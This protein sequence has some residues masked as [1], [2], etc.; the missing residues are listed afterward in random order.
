MGREGADSGELD[1]LQDVLRR[2]RFFLRHYGRFAETSLRDE[3]AG[4]VDSLEAAMT[5]NMLERARD[6]AAVICRTLLFGSSVACVLLAAER[7]VAA[8]DPILGDTIRHQAV[9]LRE[10]C[11]RGD[12]TEVVT[13]RLLRTGL[14]EA[15]GKCE[16]DWRNIRELLPE[17][18]FREDVHLPSEGTLRRKGSQASNVPSS[19]LWS[20]SGVADAII[21][22]GYY[23]AP[24]SVQWRRR[25]AER[26]LSKLS[27]HH[28]ALFFKS[29]VLE[30]A[31]EVVTDL[32]FEQLGEEQE[33][34]QSYVADRELDFSG[35][36]PY[37]KALFFN[38]VVVHDAFSAKV[39]DKKV[40]ALRVLSWGESLHWA[41]KTAEGRGRRL[42]DSVRFGGARLIVTVVTKWQPL[43]G[44]ARSRAVWVLA[45]FR[46][47]FAFISYRRDTGWEAAQL[48][49]AIL[50]THQIRVFLDV[51]SSR[52]GEFAGT[53]EE[54]IARA[55]GVVVVLTRGSL[56]SGRRGPDDYFHKEIL[57][58]KKTGKKIIPVAFRGFRFHGSMPE[59]LRFLK[60]HQQ[61]RWQRGK[62]RKAV[63]E[64]VDFVSG[65]QVRPMNAER[66]RCSP[67]P[68]S[69]PGV[70]I[71]YDP[72]H[73]EQVAWILY[74]E[75]A[76]R[77]ISAYLDLLDRTPGLEEELT[78]R[79][80]EQ[81][82][83]F[84]VVLNREKSLQTLCDKNSLFSKQ[85]AYALRCK[86]DCEIVPFVLDDLDV[87]GVPE[88]LRRLTSLRRVDFTVEDFSEAVED[89]VDFCEPEGAVRQ[90]AT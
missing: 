13:R 67:F 49:R 65:K 45:F 61:V 73:G 50:E 72:E 37:Q 15:L 20:A 85:V 82:K 87:S 43:L 32:V 39:L 71:A 84:A 66:L 48:V 70:F 2:A 38:A 79:A 22:P 4:Q 27:A 64:L 14:D 40:G 28:E 25:L 7:S 12:P 76:R 9:H 68:A 33:S 78:F 24:G 77:D 18:R 74:I 30:S 1:R 75:F 86:R 41:I 51:E 5:D 69:P 10:Q 53:L 35:L 83:Y 60:D 17:A 63:K 36:S 42:A 54:N 19:E 11:L 34:Q 21:K 8:A 52:V 58:A 16:C 46:R 80:M 62:Y 3:L 44:A 57:L 26:A 59:Q 6:V 56:A 23:V 47:C 29:S 88:E 55:D 31:I 90:L 89:L 81:Y